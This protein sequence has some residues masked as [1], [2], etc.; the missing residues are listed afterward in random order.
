M[1]DYLL[2]DISYFKSKTQKYRSEFTQPTYFI[3]SNFR[4]EFTTKK[5]IAGPVYICPGLL[6]SFYLT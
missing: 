5:V 4:V 1:F 3:V 2:G 6:C